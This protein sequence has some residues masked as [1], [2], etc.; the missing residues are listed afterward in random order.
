VER[1]Q[2]SGLITDNHV[3]FIP[4]APEDRDVTVTIKTFVM[5]AR[6]LT[7]STEV[8]SLMCRVATVRS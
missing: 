2:K 4:L 7:K 1:L 5:C 6:N 8:I 3:L